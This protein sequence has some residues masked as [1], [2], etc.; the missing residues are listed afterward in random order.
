M[1]TDDQP[2]RRHTRQRA[3]VTAALEQTDEFVSAQDLHASLR[4]GGDRIGLATVYRS[5]QTLSEDGQVDV[6]RGED[7]EALYR[8]CSTGHHHH[9]VC[10]SCGR[11]VEVESRVVERWAAGVARDNGFVDAV[12]TLEI[13]GTCP[14]C[15]ARG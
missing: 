6:R 4:A 8:R 5:L 1:T 9:L 2:V 11:T 7:G 14:D 3:A 15:A 10:R 13:T 12:H